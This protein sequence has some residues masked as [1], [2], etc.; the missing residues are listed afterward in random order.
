V[1]S[2]R[3]GAYS[4]ALAEL[5]VAAGPAPLRV[6]GGMALVLVLPGFVLACLMRPGGSFDRA[7]QILAVCALSIVGLGAICAAGLAAAAWG[8]GHAE[9]RAPWRKLRRPKIGQLGA[10][11]LAGA[12]LGVE[13]A[14]GIGLAL[15]G[16]DGP[17]FTQLWALRN[18][19]GVV[20]V[21]VRSHEKTAAVYRLRVSAGAGDRRA[22]VIELRPGQQWIATGALWRNRRVT[23]TLAKAGRSGVYR[24]VHLTP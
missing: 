21:G 17:G 3:A 20:Q 15:Q 19:T 23:V 4:L 5:A 24:R 8:P 2:V 14:I 7:E 11:L 16:D 13:A 6:L 18:A 9:A 22:A 12:V 10:G 1:T